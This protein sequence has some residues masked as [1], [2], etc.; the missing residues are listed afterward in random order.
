MNR[1]CPNQAEYEV[2]WGPG[3]EDS[4]FCCAGHVGQMYNRRAVINTILRLEGD[5]RPPSCAYEAEAR[6][7]VEA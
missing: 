7:Y 6:Y 2:L 3:P 1:K 5:V 4:Q